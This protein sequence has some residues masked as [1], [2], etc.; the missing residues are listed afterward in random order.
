MDFWKERFHLVT[1][2]HAENN[3][4]VY[5][6]PLQLEYTTSCGPG[7]FVTL[8]K[9]MSDMNFLP[10]LEFN[11]EK[12]ELTVVIPNTEDGLKDRDLLTALLNREI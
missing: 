6:K 12:N 2:Q 5:K 10:S 3:S 4:T 7:R 8:V 1:I 11:R 9:D